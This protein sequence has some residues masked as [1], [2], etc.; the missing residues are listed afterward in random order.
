LSNIRVTYSGL[1]AF[2]VALIG[3]ITGTIFVIMVTRRLSPE[4]FGLWTLIGSL[5][6]YVTI[7]EPIVTYWTTRQIARGERVAKTAISTSG[8]FSGVGIIA[9]FGIALFTAY[10]LEVDFTILLIASLLIPLTFL[11]NI[12]NSISLGYKPQHVSFGSLSFEITKIPLGIIFVVLLQ[13]GIIG[14]LITTILASSIRL[15]LLFILLKDQIPGTINFATI[16]FWLKMSWLTVYQ[17][18]YG[19]IYKFDV[20]VFSILTGSLTGIAYWGAAAAISNL[21][22]HSRSLSQ[23]LYPK[24]LATSRNEIAEENFKR[25]MYFAIPILGVT[26]VFVKPMMYILNPIYAEG[27]FIAII[28]S[29]RSFVNMIMGFFMSILESYE[30]VDLDQK[31]GFR[32][33]MKSNLF[34]TPTIMILISVIYVGGLAIFLVFPGI[35]HTDEINLVVGWS[36]ILLFVSIGFMLLSALLV[37]KRYQISIPFIPIGKYSIVTL[38]SSI[39]VYLII[40]NYLIYT[41]SVYDFIPQLIPIIILGGIMYFG[42]TYLIDK[43]TRNLFTSILREIKNKLR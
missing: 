28:I 27:F 2:S 30:K 22:V 32:K 20:L 25:T 7:I 24:L 11:T 42:L 4:E 31:A 1:I 39:I 29:I 8:V 16:K 23:G 15:I 33:Y 41:E 3:V 35:D 18:S 36:Y 19:L 10:T 12:L 14:A 37:Q 43:S 38:A 17:S 9:Y 34:L 6:G 21:V 5:V 13:F 40:E 26:I